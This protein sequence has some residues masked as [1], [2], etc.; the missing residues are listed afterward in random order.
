MPRRHRAIQTRI[1]PH[2]KRYHSPGN[3][4]RIVKSQSCTS[5]NSRPERNRVRG[6]ATRAAPGGEISLIVGPARNDNG[7]EDGLRGRQDSDTRTA[8]PEV[9]T[10]R[11]GLFVFSFD[12]QGVV[13]V[14]IETPRET[15]LQTAPRISL[16]I[17]MRIGR[18]VEFPTAASVGLRVPHQ[19]G[20]E[21]AVQVGSRIA[22]RTYPPT[23][24]RTRLAITPGTVVETVP[25]VTR[26][27]SF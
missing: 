12:P 11:G 25:T 20:P 18:E 3:R 9:R 15:L 7:A 2:V 4:D 1:Q 14:A 23:S 10:P 6:E 8:K 26:E 21:V 27:V 19:R 22:G 13:E 16:R 17:V 5:Q 24:A